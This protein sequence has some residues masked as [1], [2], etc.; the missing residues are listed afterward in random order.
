M[1]LLIAL[2]ARGL[3]VNL[4]L[5]GLQGLLGVFRRPPPASPPAAA[6][7]APFLEISN[8]RSIK[9]IDSEARLLEMAADVDELLVSPALGSNQLNVVGIDC[10]WRPENYFS[11]SSKS[12]DKSLANLPALLFSGVPGQKRK[13][14]RRLWE[15]LFYMKK[16]SGGSSGGGSVGGSSG[17]KKSKKVGSSPVLLLQISSRRT[18]WVVDLLQICRQVAPG[19]GKA[20]L[21]VPLTP[22]EQLLDSILG[23]LMRADHV[24]KVGLG[25]TQDLKRLGWSYPW[26]PN[27]QAFRSVL[28]IQTLAKKAYPE[29]AGRDLEGLSK[30]CVRQLGGGINKELQCS[31]WALRPLSDAQLRYAS[32]DASVLVDL[33]DSLLAMVLRGSAKAVSLEALQAA[34]PV[35]AYTIAFPQS[36]RADGGKEGRRRRRRGAEAVEEEAVAGGLEE[37]EG[38]AAAADEN[39]AEAEA[40]AVHLRDMVMQQLSAVGGRSRSRT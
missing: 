25:L 32:L 28:D 39:E 37:G 7:P 3:R 36:P 1:M 8:S 9:L 16:K 30:L 26:L 2:R 17:S 23:R 21:G 19:T 20:M 10:E 18:I 5:K 15:R 27:T 22:S 13:L 35:H 38:D 40:E 14:L 31:D 4:N 33:F 6:T 12:A 24:L 34:V 11:A 29:V